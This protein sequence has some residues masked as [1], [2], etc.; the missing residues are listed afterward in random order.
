MAG[1]ILVDANVLLD[2]L[3]DD[4]QWRSWSSAELRKAKASGAMAVNPI[5]CSEVATAFEFYWLK[6][7]EWL[8]QAGILKEPLPFEASTI[9]AAAHREYRRRGGLRGTPLPDFYIGAH[10]E[11]AGHRLLTRDAARYAAYFP[12]VTLF[13]PWRGQPKAE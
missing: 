6:L 10:A 2:I 11:F 1:T 3:T 13:A 9:A 5:I 4:P 12:S 7:D 8:A